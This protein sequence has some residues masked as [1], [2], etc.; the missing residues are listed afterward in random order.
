[1]IKEERGNLQDQIDSSSQ[2]QDRSEHE[3]QLYREG[4]DAHAKI[5]SGNVE[6]LIKEVRDLRT[7]V[8]KRNTLLVIATVL[9][10][11]FGFTFIYLLSTSLNNQKAIQHQTSILLAVTGCRADDTYESCRK[12]VLQNSRIEGQKR[13]KQ[14]ECRER[15]IHIGDDE[16]ETEAKCKGVI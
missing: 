13:I 4:S 5:L 9:V 10:I 3:S 8:N 7:V 14:V 12:T 6:A 1:M 16:A 2:R 15:S 11:I